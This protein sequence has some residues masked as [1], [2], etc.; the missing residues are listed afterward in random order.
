[1]DAVGRCVHGDERTGAA[2][3]GRRVEAPQESCRWLLSV[4]QRE[5][6]R[7]PVVAV[8]VV[9]AQR[10]TICEKRRGFFT[11]RARAR[12]PCRPVSGAPSRACDP[13]TVRIPLSFESVSKECVV[14]E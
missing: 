9:S 8:V 1:M 7:A 5:R 13:T 12:Q 2:A 6:E 4:G 11:A 3:V 14:D 10:E